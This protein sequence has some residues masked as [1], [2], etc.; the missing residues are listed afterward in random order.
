MAIQDFELSK[1]FPETEGVS[2]SRIVYEVKH[3]VPISRARFEYL[4]LLLSLCSKE[5]RL[6]H[7]EASLVNLFSSSL[8]RFL[9]CVA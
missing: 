1:M 4:K 6:Q 7:C 5:D 8:P 3:D 2:G 9:C